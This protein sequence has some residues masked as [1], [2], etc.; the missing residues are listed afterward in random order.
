MANTITTPQG[1]AVYPRIDT[2]RHKVQRRRL[3]FLQASRK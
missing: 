1:K 3:V 2:P